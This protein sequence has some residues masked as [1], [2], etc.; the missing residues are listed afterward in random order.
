MSDFFSK[1]NDKVFLWKII[2]FS[3]VGTIIIQVLLYLQGYYSFSGDESD[4]TLL[5][6]SWLIGKMP[7][8]E[9]WLPF[10]TIIN[11]IFLKYFLNL[12]WTPRIVGLIFGL[13]SVSA[14]VWFSQ[15]ILKDRL[16]TIISAILAVFFP[17]FVILRVVPLSE[18]MYFFFIISG[19]SF[20]FKWLETGR[21]VYLI[22]VALLFAFAGSVR[23]EGWIFS[24]SFIIFLIIEFYTH[25]EIQLKIIAILSFILLVFPVFWIL[26]NMYETGNPLEFIV[27]SSE[28]YKLHFGFS[29]LPM[30]K[31]NLITQFIYQNI[32]YL[33]FAGFFSFLFYL[34][35]DSK[36]RRWSVAF[37]LSFLFLA[38]L[39]VLGLAMPSHAYWRI[40]L[41]WNILLI[42]FTAHFII[43][44]SSFLAEILKKSTRTILMIIISVLIIY[45]SF[46]IKRII[47]FSYFTEDDISAGKFLRENVIENKNNLKILIDTSDW[48]Y[49]NVMVA[50]NHPQSFIIN[51]QKDPALPTNQIIGNRKKIDID[52]LKDLRIYYIFL[53]NKDLIDFVKGNPSLLKVKKLGEWELYKVK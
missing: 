44:F 41:I 51:A 28:R 17:P 4:R 39:S 35:T 6:Y 26:K 11:G 10:H 30:L 14:I 43:K 16:V 50:S 21:T 3:L 24:G 53:E 33:N 31:Y 38:V 47:S 27:S 13:L 29:I 20:L 48:N 15:I 52:Y 7:K 18:V 12:F 25:K 34:L 22:F 49:L 46:Q 40:P 1:D 5:A 19:A 45:F 8:G 9:P 42:P 37:S 32:L 23:Y 36:I 2:S